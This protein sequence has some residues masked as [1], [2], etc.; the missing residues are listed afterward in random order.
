MTFEKDSDVR[1]AEKF[2]NEK[3]LRKFGQP[4]QVKRA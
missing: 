4:I 3:Q 1:K 2:I